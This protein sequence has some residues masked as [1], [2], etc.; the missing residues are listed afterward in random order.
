[1]TQRYRLTIEYNGADYAGWQRQ[2]KAGPQTIQGEIEKAI[3]AFSGQDVTVQSSGRTDAGVHAYGQI[4]HVDLE[5]LTRPMQP[6]EIAKAINA[7]LYPQP[8]C[9]LS[10]EQVSD[11]F[12]ARFSAKNKRYIYRILNRQAFP[13]IERGFV[14]HIRRPLDVPAMQEA[15]QVLLGH[16]D[17]TTFR[18]SECQAKTAMRTLD[19]LEVSA[20]EYDT[21]GGIEIRIA[22]E[23]KSFLHH[24]VRNLAGTLSL[25]G[26][27]K[28]SA[29][30]VAAA[31]EAKDRCAGGPTAP[32]SG[33]FLERVDYE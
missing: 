4:A 7:H 32:A 15:A 23:A 3:K 18:D 2:E 33:L 14:W 21:G 26:E 11:D 30:D 25:V 29:A 16:H 6:F 5:D 24:M 10:A 31:L 8:I 20:R 12:H 1:M 9:I 28:W 22:A 17:F 13:A 19:R 27:G